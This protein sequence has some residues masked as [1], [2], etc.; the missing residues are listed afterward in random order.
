MLKGRLRADGI[1]VSSITIDL[2]HQP[3]MEVRAELKFVDSSNG[4]THGTT[5]CSTWGR[6]THQKVKE[7]IEVLEAD[8]AKTL[9]E[10]GTDETPTAKVQLPTSGLID[11]LTAEPSEV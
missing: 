4:T 6:D 2:L 9:F 7:L 11:H 10:G 5:A 8:A 3:S 1:A